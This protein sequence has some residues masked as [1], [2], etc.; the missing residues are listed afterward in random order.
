[1]KNIFWLLII[2]SI[3]FRVFPKLMN[4][5]TIQ[6]RTKQ[7][8]AFKQQM[9]NDLFGGKKTKENTQ[10]VGYNPDN[11]YKTEFDM[12]KKQKGHRQKNNR[13]N[14]TNSKIKYSDPSWV[15]DEETW[16]KGE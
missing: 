2:A 14:Q 4:P 11:V 15:K 5:N 13:Q 8:Q 10:Q 3:I 16:I 1:M 6:Q 12:T 9:M 7:N